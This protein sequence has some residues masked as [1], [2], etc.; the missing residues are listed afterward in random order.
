[1]EEAFEELFWRELCPVGVSLF[2]FWHLLFL[3]AGI[4]SGLM[5]DYDLPPPSIREMTP[6]RT[7]PPSSL[8]F[9]SFFFSL[10]WEQRAKLL[11]LIG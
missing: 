3:S 10:S 6:V 4:S 11:V 9:F 7:I 5:L 1:L 8:S 2:Q